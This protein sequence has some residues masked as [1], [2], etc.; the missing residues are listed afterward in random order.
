MDGG[1]ILE[2]NWHL[3]DLGCRGLKLGRLEAYFDIGEKLR[4]LR[5]PNKD[6][7]SEPNNQRINEKERAG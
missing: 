3:V 5:L 6:R 1:R 7:D 4:L 2:T